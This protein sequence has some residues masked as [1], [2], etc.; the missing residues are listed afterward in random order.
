MGE[1]GA[2]GQEA[3]MTGRRSEIGKCGNRGVGNREVGIREVGIREVR[4]SEMGKSDFGFLDFW[5]FESCWGIGVAHFT[6]AGG[7]VIFST[8]IFPSA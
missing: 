7:I 1:W 8:I 5:I 2:S 3:E 4:K 6:W